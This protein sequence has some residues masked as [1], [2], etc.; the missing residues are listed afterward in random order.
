MHLVVAALAI[1]VITCTPNPRAYGDRLQIALPL[2]AWGCAIT[3]RTGAEFALRFFGMLAVAHGSKAALG[4]AAINLRPDGGDKGFP[5]AHTSAAVL[6]ASSIVHDC[7]AGHPVGKAIV[8]IA[9]AFVGGSRI[10]A[11]KHNIWQVLAGGLLGWGS[12]RI[13]RRKSKLRERLVTGTS[14]LMRAALSRLRPLRRSVFQIGL[15]AALAAGGLLWSD[16]AAAEIEISVYG[17]TQSAPHSS[18][19]DS[20]LGS[21][22]VR[23]LGKSFEAPPYY[24]LRVTWWRDERFG[25]GLEFNHAKVYADNPQSYGYDVLELTDGI[26]ILTANVW[27]RWDLKGRITPYVGAGIGI[28]VPHVEVQRVGESRTFEYQLTGPAVQLVVG[29]A[30]EVNDRWSVFGEYKGTYSSNKMDIDAGGTIETD[31]ITN[32]LNVGVSLKF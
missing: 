9:A 26:N 22:R 21:Q 25:F 28:S 13:L 5:S 7:I 11:N 20:V 24:G 14:S 8:V 18:I 17:G 31:I 27:R 23:W 32:A 4:S 10:E 12:D 3:N 29:A 1:A 15:A 19:D 2:I 30:W 6:G 16:R